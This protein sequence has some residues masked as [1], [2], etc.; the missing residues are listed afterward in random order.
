MGKKIPSRIFFQT[1]KNIFYLKQILG[2]LNAY[3]QAYKVKKIL[4]KIR[5]IKKNLT[6]IL[7]IL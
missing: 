6:K 3:T 7:S 5:K 2:Y 4:K 1:Y